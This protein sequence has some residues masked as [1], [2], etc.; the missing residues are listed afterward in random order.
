MGVLLG[1][2]ESLSFRNRSAIVGE[3]PTWIGGRLFPPGCIEEGDKVFVER[4]N[5][6]QVLPPTFVR[7]NRLDLATVWV[8]EA[9][10]PC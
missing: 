10:W 5:I 3:A 7:G 4:K 1:G 9:R 8:L 2:S 6:D